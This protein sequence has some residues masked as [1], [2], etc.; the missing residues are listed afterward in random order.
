MDA[1]YSNS[2]INIL[3]IAETHMLTSYGQEDEQFTSTPGVD[4]YYNILN[5]VQG[6]CC[7]VTSWNLT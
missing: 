1:Q 3:R 2:V 5:L 4:D 7:A 6:P